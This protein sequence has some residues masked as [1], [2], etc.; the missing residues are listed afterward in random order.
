MTVQS[1]LHASGEASRRDSDRRSPRKGTRAYRGHLA[2]CRRCLHAMGGEREIE[3]IMSAV[4]RARDEERWEPDLRS[5]LARRAKPRH[6]GFARRRS[7]RLLPRHWS[8]GCGEAGLSRRRSGSRQQEARRSWRSV[9]RLRRAVKGRAE[10]LAVS[11]RRPSRRR[12]T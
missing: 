2:G 10:S 12:S 4:T 8:A 5:Q 6:A 7:R 11:E 3:R 9:R 1:R